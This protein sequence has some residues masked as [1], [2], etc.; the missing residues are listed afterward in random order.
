MFIKTTTWRVGETEKLKR[1]KDINTKQV[2]KATK[3]VQIT[4]L[5]D[6]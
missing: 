1:C 2:V 6:I 4:H 3:V 5:K